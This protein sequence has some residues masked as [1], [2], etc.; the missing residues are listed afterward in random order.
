MSTE[1][2]QDDWTEWDEERYVR[3]GYNAL[4][5]KIDRILSGSMAID[6]VS[7]PKNFSAPAALDGNKILFNHDWIK[8]LAKDDD[9]DRLAVMLAINMHELGHHQFTP[10]M[11][12]PIWDSLRRAAYSSAPYRNV[13]LIHNALNVLEDQRQ[14]LFMSLRYPKA[15]DYYRLANVRLMRDVVKN[16]G[17]L[18]AENYLL[19]YGRRHFLPNP[20]IA[21]LRAQLVGKYGPSVVDEAD[22]IIDE[23]ITIAS[24]DDA[25]LARMWELALALADLFPVPTQN[26]MPNG[27][28]KARVKKPQEDIAEKAKDTLKTVDEHNEDENDAGG[29]PTDIEQRDG[30]E[31]AEDVDG[32][33]DGSKT[34]TAPSQSKKEPKPPIE[35]IK[36]YLEELE[37][38]SE[39]RVADDVD[40]KLDS[41]E[42]TYDS[43]LGDSEKSVP[44]PTNYLP[45][46]RQLTALFKNIVQD[47][48]MQ[49]FRNQRR[50]HLDVR[51]IASCLATNSN[52]MF[53]HR[54]RDL[55][56]NARMAVA[57]SFDTSGSM[58]ENAHIAMEAAL[59]VAKA[60]EMA[61]HVSKISA[62]SDKTYYIKNWRDKRYGANDV[63]GWGGGT[64]PL[65]GFKKLYRD[66][67]AV[68]L[69]EE[70]VNK[71]FIIITDGQ[72]ESDEDCHKALNALRK[73]QGVKVYII[74]INYEPSIGTQTRTADG[75]WEYHAITLDKVCADAQRTIKN[76]DELL[77]TMKELLKR[78]AKDIAEDVRA[79][80]T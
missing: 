68:G 5:Q 9:W 1:I 74:G 34:E 79:R 47:L 14:E 12:N 42:G 41:L 57:V 72:W 18:P 24:N 10:A 36:E 59:T 39:D 67:E 16:F 73:R 45:R 23:Y 62:F 30:D 43:D 37:E 20:L 71:V 49:D 78:L 21:H 69:A 26:C 61:G 31:E 4:C 28:V 51:R 22:A 35:D 8:K 63:P 46:A 58:G 48:T 50:G 55:T 75:G 53:R 15:R 11:D 70:I 64:S 60:V 25:R 52:R 76:I 17:E 13:N 29:N 66:F 7:A 40:E 33:D 80:L 38:K 2:E 44:L 3:E 6:V 56:N 32:G 54:Q 77:P 65:Q 27:T 19:Y